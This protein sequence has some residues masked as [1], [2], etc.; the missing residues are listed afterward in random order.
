MDSLESDIRNADSLLMKYS[1]IRQIKNLQTIPGIGL[2]S[3]MVIYSEIG[4]IGRFMDSGHL[5]SYAGMI[6]SLRQSSDIIHHGMNTNQGSG[7]PRWIPVERLRIN[8]I[9]D[10][11]SSISSYY[12]HP[13]RGKGKIKAIYWILKE[14]RPYYSGNQD[15]HAGPGFPTDGKHRKCD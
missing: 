14:N 7:Y 8:M 10:P 11:G 4:H 15:Q 9:N 13:A 12:K 1:G 5:S 3:V 2:F 6:P